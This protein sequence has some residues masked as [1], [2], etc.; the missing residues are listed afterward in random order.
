MKTTHRE[1][2]LA[3]VFM[4][5]TGIAG[6]MFYGKGPPPAATNAPGEIACQASRCHVQY[7]LNSGP[8]VLEVTGIPKHYQPGKR[9]PL[10]ISLAQKGQ[11]RWGFQLTALDSAH[12]PAGEVVVSNAEHTQLKS[13]AMPDKSE[14]HY[15]EHT[16]G[17]TFPGTPNGPVV[18]EVIWQAPD[19]VIGPICFY[20][21]GNA[22]DFNKKPWGDYIYTRI[23]TAHVFLLE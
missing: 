20:T 13:E 21:A 9:Y 17:G 10:T 6:G 7:P 16:V 15:I 4:V 11:Q 12:Q 19:E 5:M 8:G 3:T 2:Y 18:W 22:A 1:L 23:D 14:R